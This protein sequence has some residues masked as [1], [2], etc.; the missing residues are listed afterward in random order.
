MDQEKI[1]KFIYECRKNKNITQME[2][3]SKLLVSNRAVSKWENGLSMPD[4]ALFNPLCEILGVSINELLAGEKNVNDDKITL[5][6]IKYY[7]GK[8]KRRRFIMTSIILL[9][10]I[11]MILGMYMF[12]N[13]N[14]CKIY[15]IDTKNEEFFVNGYLMINQK[16]KILT[17]NRLDY[18]FDSNDKWCGCVDCE[19]PDIL[20]RDM[21]ISILKGEVLL[22]SIDVKDLNT[23][24]KYLADV[25]KNVTIDL[26][27]LDDVLIDDWDSND[28]RIV[29]GYNNYQD[30]KKYNVNLDIKLDLHGIY[31]NNKLFY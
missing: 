18:N 24:S 31:A 4:V 5:E 15:S 3:A 19:C 21:E 20:A 12:N 2:L 14:K 17:I 16:N 1:G 9:V 11:I 30:S 13:Y 23:D 28:Y 6:A 26:N 10:G 7:N 8:T 25:I 27:E 22:K 29:I